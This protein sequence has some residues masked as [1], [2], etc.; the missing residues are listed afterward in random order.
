ML[1]AASG[2]KRVLTADLPG[3]FL[4]ASAEPAFAA[5]PADSVVVEPA[6]SGLKSA[7]AEQAWSGEP[8]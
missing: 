2:P 1:L 8:A 4:L 3:R 5:E 6:G 7:S